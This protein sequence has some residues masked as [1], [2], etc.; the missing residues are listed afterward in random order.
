MK[1]GDKIRL[2]CRYSDLN[3][4]S[5]RPDLDGRIVTVLEV[6]ERPNGYITVDLNGLRLCIFRD[7]VGEVIDENP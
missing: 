4:W 1:P 2:R 5:I 3:G 7:A 6:E